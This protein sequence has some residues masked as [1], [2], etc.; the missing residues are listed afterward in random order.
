MYCVT[1]FLSLCRCFDFYSVKIQSN[2]GI[3]KS[4]PCGLIFTILI[5]ACV[6]L[7]VFNMIQLSGTYQVFTSKDFLQPSQ[8]KYSLKTG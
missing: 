4:S 1:K 5:I 6:C 7:Q 8:I 2:A 3:A